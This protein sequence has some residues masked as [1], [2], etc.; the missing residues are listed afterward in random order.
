VRTDFLGTDDATLRLGLLME[1]AQ[2]QQ[3]LAATAIERLRE[4]TLS[5]DDI[6]REEIRHTLIEELGALVEDGRRAAESLRRLS[7]TA[8]LRVTGWSVGVA[9]LAAALPLGAA[10][11]LLPSRVEVSALRATRDELQD[12]IARLAQQGG[13]VQLRHCGAGKRLC[14]RVERSQP[15]YGES[16]D[17]LVVKGY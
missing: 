5:L 16:A 14:V 8:S 10:T 1:A 9:V 7:R 12:N 15:A 17:Y 3:A 6:V 11:W 4:H 2:T 13:R